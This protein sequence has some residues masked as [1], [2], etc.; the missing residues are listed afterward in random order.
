VLATEDFI[1]KYPEVTAR[2]VKQLVR[3]AH[4]ASQESN[5]EAFIKLSVEHSGNPEL[6][7]RSELEGENLKER[8]SPLIDDDLVADYQRVLDEGLKLGL[9]RQAYN[10]KDWFAP[11]FVQQAVKDLKLEK[12]WTE[13]D[14][15]GKAIK[16]KAK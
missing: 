8:F 13:L 12:F 7:I 11:Q 15:Q 10:V 6:G 14:A 3:A 1:A 16:A 2:L 5:R 9:I 4:F